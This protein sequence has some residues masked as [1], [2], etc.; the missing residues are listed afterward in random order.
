MEGG[1][2]DCTPSSTRNEHGGEQVN[3]VFSMKKRRA[4]KN[5]ATAST[6]AKA[7]TKRAKLLNESHEE[8]QVKM[9]EEE[10]VDH[11]LECQI[12]ATRAIRDLEI[13]RLITGLRLLRSN[14]S[15]EQLQTP[16][17]QFFKENYPNLSLVRNEKDGQF[18]VEWKDKDG[19]LSRSQT[20]ERNINAFILQQMYM[21]FPGLVPNIGGFEFPSKAVET[22]LSDS[23]N[24]QI[25][26]SVLEEQ[27]DTQI[28]GLQ[29]AFK[30]PGGNNHRLSVGKIPKT[31]RLPKQGEM[32][33]SVCGSPLGVYKEDNMEAIHESEEG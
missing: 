20:D 4:K 16:V 13:E 21:G 26:D 29:D 5:V 30:T 17:L 22:N 25:P 1:G 10:V 27:S 15:E 8:H 12:A 24:V 2:R 18:E 6:K 32:L 11:E 33:L 28:L 9:Q 7:S 14:F 3:I 23:E 19:N 31:Q